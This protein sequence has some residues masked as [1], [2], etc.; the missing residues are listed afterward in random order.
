[1]ENL[2]QTF[3]NPIV[4]K[5]IKWYFLI[6]PKMVQD[7]SKPA[8]WAPMVGPH[9]YHFWCPKN[10]RSSQ[11]RK[12]HRRCGK[13]IGIDWWQGKTRRAQQR[14]LKKP[15]LPLWWNLKNTFPSLFHVAWF[16]CLYLALCWTSTRNQKQNY[17]GSSNL[18][19]MFDHEYLALLFY[20]KCTWGSVLD[21]DFFSMEPFY[22][23]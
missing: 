6:P 3:P 18:G 9:G 15:S 16:S 19:R 22:S 14:D 5:I 21:Q 11:V 10:F 2:C 8:W 13:Q 4:T 23:N 7:S 12:H 17:S 20:L 1:M